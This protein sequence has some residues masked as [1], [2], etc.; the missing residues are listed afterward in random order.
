MIERRQRIPADEV[1]EPK[2]W[3]LPF[4]TE[5]ESVVKAREKAEEAEAQTQVEEQ[6][7]E[8]EP[9][10]AEQ[11]EHIR[12][13]AYN[14]GLEQGLVEGRQNG[15]KLGRQ[16]GHDEGLKSGQE[17]G[18]KLGYQAGLE[19]GK[20]KAQ[21]EG[22]QQ[23][24]LV[25]TNLKSVIKQLNIEFTQQ[26]QSLENIFPDLVAQLAK[27][28]VT[29]E[30]SQ[31]SEHIVAL[32]NAAIDALPVDKNKLFIEVNPLDF[33]FLETAFE[34]SEWLC[35][36]KAVDKIEAGG[37]RLVTEHSVADFTLSERWAALIKQY[38]NQLKMG[39]IE[40]EKHPELETQIELENKTEKDSSEALTDVV[41]E[42]PKNGSQAS[43]PS[44]S[45]E[46]NPSSNQA[47]QQPIPDVP[48]QSPDEVPETNPID[49]QNQYSPEVSPDI[50]APDQD[51]PEILPGIDTSNQDKPEVLAEGDKSDVEGPQSPDAKA[52]NKPEQPDNES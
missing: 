43:S 11:L 14:E 38:K 29:E 33:P 37:C 18:R 4:W 28:V 7:I 35:Q 5:P 15:E 44:S 41:T 47:P 17:E 39:L 3:S 21:S 36:L 34:Q 46:P 30:L 9:F 23:T 26:K 2:L 13:E 6:E 19:E 16:E 10:T 49:L 31:G 52:Q 40:S 8:V 48:S 12:Q 51:N 22:Q 27:A 25:L 24:D 45:Q 20:T 32:V 42:N 50:D 1:T